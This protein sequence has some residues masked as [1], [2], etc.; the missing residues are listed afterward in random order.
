[1]GQVLKREGSISERVGAKPVLVIWEDAA[2]NFG[3]LSGEVPETLDGLVETVGWLVAETEA[4]VIIAQSLTN[5]AHAQ[6]LQIP[7]GMVHKIVILI[8]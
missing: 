8:E 6:T 4:H 3:W 2:H 1:M 7:V 5:G